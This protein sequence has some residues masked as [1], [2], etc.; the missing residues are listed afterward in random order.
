MVNMTAS[1]TRRTAVCLAAIGAIGAVSALAGCTSTS[2]DNK[3]DVSTPE[4]HDLNPD[5]SSTGG[6]SAPVKEFRDQ[7]ERGELT[8][9]VDF[10]NAVASM[11]PLGKEA[12]L[13]TNTEEGFIEVGGVR[14]A[15][16]R[17]RGDWKGS[18]GITVERAFYYDSYEDADAV[19]GFGPKDGTEYQLIFKFSNCSPEDLRFVVVEVTV[20]NV[21]A[22]GPYDG[23][24]WVYNMLAS[25]IDNPPDS[26]DIFSSSFLCLCSSAP[27]D[28][29]I[30]AC[31]LGK[32][33]IPGPY[34][35]RGCAS[36]YGFAGSGIDGYYIVSPGDTQRLVLGYWV[37][38]YVD[39]ATLYFY[40]DYTSG[41]K[42]HPELVFEIGLGQEV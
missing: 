16:S 24:Q 39:P 29:E 15:S 22:K 40:A 3:V 31:G 5:G 7:Y 11:V 23:A 41:S 1:V 9:Q 21:D 37:M 42:P 19:Y 38:S 10:E 4:V 18:M 34:R 14:T 28:G 30:D 27:C 8:R 33:I 6:V 25:H 2:N 20:H 36:D 26:S 35:K 12:I 13:C 17:T 32:G